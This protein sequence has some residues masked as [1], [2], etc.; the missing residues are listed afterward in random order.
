[1]RNSFLEVYTS[2]S[3]AG[4]LKGGTSLV[5]QWLKL[6]THSAGGLG[7][8]PGQGTRSHTLQLKIPHATT[9]T[10]HSQIKIFLKPKGKKR[11]WG[12][13]TEKMLVL[14]RA[15]TARKINLNRPFANHGE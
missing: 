11:G 9:K 14:S 15:R 6:H 12:K 2:K 4:Q 1:M 5:V 3:G 7:L 13:Y 8:I 10:Q